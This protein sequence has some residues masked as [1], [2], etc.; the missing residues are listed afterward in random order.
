MRGALI[1]RLRKTKDLASAWGCSLPSITTAYRR[2]RAPLSYEAAHLVEA[3]LSFG[4]PILSHRG[5]NYNTLSHY[6]LEGACPYNIQRH[7][8]YERHQ[9]SAS[10]ERI[11][12]RHKRS[13]LECVT[14]F[15]DRVTGTLEGDD[16]PHYIWCCWAAGRAG[17]LSRF[18]TRRTREADRY[19]GVRMAT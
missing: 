17:W 11:T 3:L 19:G 2:Q 7:P 4:C 14:I 18:I 9:R 10:G 8:C 6:L 1:R 5:Q 12:R 15:Y 13:H 16:D